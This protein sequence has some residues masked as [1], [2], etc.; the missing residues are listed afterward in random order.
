MTRSIELSEKFGSRWH[1]TNFW[2]SDENREKYL[3]N[4]N[5]VTQEVVTETMKHRFI[6]SSL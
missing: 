1:V 6:E 2:M 4:P 3:K 5:Y